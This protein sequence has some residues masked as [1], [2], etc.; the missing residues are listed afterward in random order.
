MKMTISEVMDYGSICACC[1]ELGLY[2]TVN[3]SYLNLWVGSPESGFENTDLRAR[4]KDLY[5]T[6]GAEMIDEAVKY[7]KEVIEESNEELKND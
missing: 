4:S 3:G 2:I 5:D 7:L 6:T 1:E